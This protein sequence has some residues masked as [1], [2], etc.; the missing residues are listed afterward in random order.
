M[1]WS[2]STEQEIRDAAA[3]GMLEETHYLDL[4]RE[5][6]AGDAGNRGLAKDI[7]AFSLDGGTI[8]I[9][10][11]EETSPPTIAPMALDGLSERVEQIGAMRVQEGVAVSTTPIEIPSG[12]GLGVLVVRIPASPR[13]PHMADGKYYG[14]GDKRNNVLSHAEVLRLHQQQSMQ[15]Q[16]VIEVARNE[17]DKFLTRAA[18]DEPMLVAVAV[19]LSPKPGMLTAFSAMV[20]DWQGLAVEMLEQAG[21]SELHHYVPTFNQAFG[22]RR[23]AGGVAITTGMENDRFDSD[24]AAELQIRE[25]GVLVV[26]SR[27]ATIAAS[28]RDIELQYVFE[29]L[30]VGHTKLL[31][32]LSGVV[33]TK[34]DYAGSW[35]FGLIAA[36]IGG[37]TSYAV[38]SHVF[39]HS[40]PYSDDEYTAGTSASLEEIETA[41]QR[42]VDRLLGSLLR[43]LNSRERFPELNG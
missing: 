10:V 8:L 29:E 38:H 13:A 22:F 16:D 7:A 33:S 5:L 23:R 24:R 21:V 41:P 35:E 14:R 43:S 4:K 15:Q 2:P 31:V 40:E 19:P 12:S 26:G 27:R 18:S 20:G 28:R 42:V 32:R 37:K 36:G 9:G 25:S 11:D 3:N 30:I 17:H 6:P 34:F 39:G 1:I